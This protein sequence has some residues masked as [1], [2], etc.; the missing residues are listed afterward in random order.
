MLDRESG[1]LAHDFLI[2]AGPD[3]THVLNAIS[4]AFTSA[5]PFAR[6]VCDTHIF[7]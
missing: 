6:Y 3:S 7:R 2:E 5:L 1:E 4:P